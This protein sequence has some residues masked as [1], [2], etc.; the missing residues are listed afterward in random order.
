MIYSLIFSLTIIAFTNL[1]NCDDT[2]GRRWCP[3]GYQHGTQFEIGK[4]W[5]ECEDGQVVPKGCLS[6]TGRRVL[7][8]ETYD[9]Q[10][11]RMQCVLDGDGYLAILYKS[12]VYNNREYQVNERWDDGRVYYEC[13]KSASAIGG[14]PI[15][16]VDEGRQIEFDERV[17]K[18]DSV[19]SC[20]KSTNGKVEMAITGCVKNGV[21]YTI[22][23]TYEGGKF[24]YTCTDSGSKVI[25]CIHDGLRLKDGDQYHENDVIYQCKV[26]DENTM[27]VAM[28]CVQ[29][30]NGLEE[31]KKFGCFWTEGDAPY[32]YENTCKYDHDRNLAIKIQTRCQ[33]KAEQGI[34]RVEPGCYTRAN[35][36]AVGC[37][38]DNDGRLQTKTFPEDK[39]DTSLGL[40]DC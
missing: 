40:R 25:G 18:G 1:V 38:K 9:A 4:Y 24:W 26:N 37:V 23:E 5:Y 3:G 20:R 6:D 15:G 27:A 30:S 31:E 21:K 32:Q 16:C 2:P 19:Y 10:D 28:G 39:L 33:Y 11:T 14:A 13:Q 7:V 36:L 34:F 35:G 29:R 17:A 8:Q 12:C 22:G